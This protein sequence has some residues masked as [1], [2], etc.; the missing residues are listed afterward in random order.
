M[1]VVHL[2]PQQIEVRDQIDFTE[3]LIRPERFPQ[4]AVS[5]F[6]VMYRVALSLRSKN[7]KPLQPGKAT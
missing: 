7:H 3:S 6:S 1:V 4:S 5:T 2:G